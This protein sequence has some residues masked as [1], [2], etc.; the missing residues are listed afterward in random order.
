MTKS[1]LIAALM[2]MCLLGVE[3]SAR[4]QDSDGVAVS[5][6]F[7]FVA[8]DVTLPAGDYRVSRNNPGANRDLAISGYKKGK[9]FVLP[10]A[11]DNG[12][13]NQPT[14][15]FEHV[16]GKYF[17]SSIKTPSGVY[18]LPASREMIMLGKASSPSSNT[19]PASDGQ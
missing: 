17:L 2:L 6:P 18:T 4:A 13:S 12:P 9:V 11:F 15:G 19:A 5:V 3:A 1:Y 8:G 16:G 14:L 10:V 7:E